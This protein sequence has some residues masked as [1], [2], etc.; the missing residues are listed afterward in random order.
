MKFSARCIM[1]LVNLWHRMRS[2]SSAC[3]ILMLSLIE[4][5]EGSI[6]THSFSFREITRGFSSTS[7]DALTWCESSV[8]KE[9]RNT[10][11]VS[12]SGLL[13]R[14]TTWSNEHGW[15]YIVDSQT[16]LRREVLEGQ[17]CGQS[18]THG[19]KIRAKDVWLKHSDRDMVGEGITYHG[20]RRGMVWRT[21]N[22]QG[23]AEFRHFAV[24]S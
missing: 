2:I 6:R 8:Q 17:S 16:H 10:D 19:G 22:N 9:I 14:S 23:R 5:T 15:G 24:S 1:N 4:L 11:L 7:F 18:W 13:W 12:I 20:G 21:I 3:L